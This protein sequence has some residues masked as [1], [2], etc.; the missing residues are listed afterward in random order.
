MALAGD[1]AQ[2]E[3]EGWRALATQLYAYGLTA[4]SIFLLYVFPPHFDLRFGTIIQVAIVAAFLVAMERPVRTPA[5]TMVA[6]L[7]AI[8]S[9]SG[10]VFG[11][12]TIVLA[13]IAW[14]AVRLRMLLREGGWQSIIAPATLG[15]TA[16]AIISSYALLGTWHVV[17]SLVAVTPTFFTNVV[18]LFGI[19]LVGLV[20]QTANNVTAYVYYLING[21]PFA[22]TQLLR[23]GVIASIYAY[24]LVA[25]YKFGGLLTTAIFYVIV[26]QIRVVQDILGVTTQLHKLEKAQDQARGLVRDLARFTD[27]ETVEFASEVQNI[28]QMMGRHLG[29]SSRD[30]DLLG[31]AAE[32]HEIGKSHIPARIRNRSVL[33]AKELAQKRTYARWGGLMIRAAD[34]LL[35]HQIADWIEFHGEHFDGTGYP[36]S[37]KGED[38][39]LA[40]RIIAVARDY[41][42]SLTGYDGAEPMEKEKA[43]TLLRQGSGTLYDP[44]LV[45]LLSELVT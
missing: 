41:V 17:S 40:S 19:V 44:R 13:V 7:T 16:T 11:A 12:W 27:T 14:V 3:R 2:E 5:V 4:F 10:V 33:N 1:H 6:P 20:F 35:P 25:T 29:M 32:L 34:A 22:V 18:E 39:P 42:R 15:Q 43:L 23:T 8:I 37:L 26:A 38:I 45:S 9:A 31:L 36:R 24:L 21:R 30:I 28:S